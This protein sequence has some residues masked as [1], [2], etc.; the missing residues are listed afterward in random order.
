MA[1]ELLFPE[2]S[3]GKEEPRDCWTVAK[4]WGLEQAMPCG[5]TLGAQ[6]SMC[7]VYMD[8]KREREALVL[9]LWR[10]IYH[11]SRADRMMP[12]SP[13]LWTYIEGTVVNV[14]S[15]NGEREGSLDVGSVEVYHILQ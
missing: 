8:G 5:H 11:C 12:P 7:S 1:G 9:V 6:G 2:Y 3:T 13:A 4:A 15:M 14:L 10:C